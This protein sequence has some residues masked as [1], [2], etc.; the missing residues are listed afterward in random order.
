MFATLGHLV[1]SLIRAFQADE[2]R[3][4]EAFIEQGNPQSV[5]DVEALDKA[6]DAHLRRQSAITRNGFV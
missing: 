1:R 4:R 2:R 6:Y 3:D 5:A